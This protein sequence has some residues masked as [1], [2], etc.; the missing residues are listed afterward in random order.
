MPM[1][2]AKVHSASNA[3]SPSATDCQGRLHLDVAL[4]PLSTA[5]KSFI[6]RL[7]ASLYTYIPK[8]FS[9]DVVVYEAK[10]TPLL[11]LP[12][13]GRTWNK[14]APQS[15]ILRIVGTHIS[16]MREPYVEALA[17]DLRRRIAEFFSINPK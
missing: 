4:H 11:Y 1:Q 2:S 17:M 7:F 13:I 16:M 3:V 9:G 14:F 8:E 5:Q 6:N 15:T 12:Q 10:I